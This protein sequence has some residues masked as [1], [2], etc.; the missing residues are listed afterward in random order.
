VNIPLSLH[1]VSHVNKEI[2]KVG[3]ILDTMKEV[4]GERLISTKGMVLQMK[5]AML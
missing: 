1:F 4:R 3:V 2:D 5:M